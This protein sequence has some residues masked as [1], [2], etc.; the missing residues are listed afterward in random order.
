MTIPRVDFCIQI[1][2]PNL[3]MGCQTSN[4]D[5]TF[6]LKTLRKVLSHVVSC[7]FHRYCEAKYHAAYYNP[8]E[9]LHVPRIRKTKVQKAFDCFV[10]KIVPRKDW[11][12]HFEIPTDDPNQT[13]TQLEKLYE[14][15]ICPYKIGPVQGGVCVCTNSKE[16]RELF[17]QTWI[18]ISSIPFI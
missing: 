2:Q 3:K 4:A 5:K 15:N 7:D 1:D 6:K 16:T 18:E 8:E 12:Y 11:I 17:I 10:Q 14:G 9:V 13:L